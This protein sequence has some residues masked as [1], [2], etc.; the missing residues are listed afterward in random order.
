MGGTCVL[1]DTD[2]FHEVGNRDLGAGYGESDGCGRGA[3]GDEFGEVGR[4]EGV[5]DDL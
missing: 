4:V 2:R 3:V 5:D 1:D